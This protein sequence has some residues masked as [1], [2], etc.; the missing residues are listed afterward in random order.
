MSLR[1]RVTA[2]LA[3]SRNTRDTPDDEECAACKTPITAVDPVRTDDGP[4]HPG[5]KRV[6]NGVAREV[7]RRNG[8]G[9]S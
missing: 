7:T 5:C 8:G 3:R 9:W 4:M 6:L 1:E 2:T